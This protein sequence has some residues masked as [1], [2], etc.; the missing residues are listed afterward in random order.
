M[1]VHSILCF[2]ITDLRV[3]MAC[4]TECPLSR[5]VAI[6]TIFIFL[7]YFS[8]ISLSVG[9]AAMHGLHQVPQKSMRTYFPLSFSNEN[10]LPLISL[11]SKTGA[12]NPSLGTVGRSYVPLIVLI[13]M[14]HACCDSSMSV[15]LRHTFPILAGVPTYLLSF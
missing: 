1:L 12:L 15:T 9:N 13:F 7:P 14:V 5:S 2:L 10:G 4:D 3:G 6:L 8:Y 11:H